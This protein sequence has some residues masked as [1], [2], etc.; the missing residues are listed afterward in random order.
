MKD[1]KRTAGVLNPTI[2]ARPAANDVELSASRPSSAARWWKFL[3]AAL[4]LATTFFLAFFEL[5]D[6]DIWYHLK[7]G[8]L[9]PRYGVPQKDWFCFKSEDEDWIDVHWGFQ[10]IVAELYGR[11]GSSG[12]V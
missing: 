4:L 11:F 10:R 7:A 5:S 6:Y 8:E 1:E 9:I 3:P 12:L 2:D